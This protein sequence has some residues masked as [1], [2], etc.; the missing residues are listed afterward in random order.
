ME[1]LSSSRDETIALG[2]KIGKGLKPGAILCLKGDLAAG[3]TTF[4]KGVAKGFGDY[5]ED[6]VN[7]P[8]FIFLNIYDGLRPVYHFDLYRLNDPDDFLHMGFDEYLFSNGICCIEWSE[9]IEK[10]LPKHCM[11]I[12]FVPL[13]VSSRK[14]KIY[15]TQKCQVC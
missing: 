5:R 11:H 10:Y 4:V 2:V 3:K 12:E 15:E 14:I 6:E 9:R 7:S 13:D 8:T 1:Y